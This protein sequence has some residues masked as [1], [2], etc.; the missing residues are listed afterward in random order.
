[1]GKKVLGTLLT[2]A[3]L[4]ACNNNMQS[5]E[6]KWAPTGKR[7]VG[8]LIEAT[9]TATIEKI[10]AQYPQA[11][12]R[13]LNPQHGLYEVFGITTEQARETAPT[14]SSVQRNSYFEFKLQ[15][16]PAPVGMKIEG[17]NPCKAASQFPTAIATLS[18]PSG[19][20][21]RVRTVELGQKIAVTSTKSKAHLLNPSQ[22]KTA[23]IVVA[24][25]A[26]KMGEQVKLMKDFEFTPD[27][28]G[29]YNIFVI[30]QDSRDVCAI[31]GLNILAT[32]NRSFRPSQQS[33]RVDL[34]KIPHLKKV[35][36]QE[37][38][39]I[40]QGAGITIAIIDTGVNY[41]HPLLAPNILVNSK[42]T[43]GAGRDGDGNGFKDDQIGY[44]FVNSDP[45]PYDDDGHGTHVAGLAAAKQ[46][47]MA[48]KAK[49]LPVKAMTSIGGDAGS[50]AAA[51]Q[52]A[53]D[54]GAKIINLS[55]GTVGA[56]AHPM[57]VKAV[58]Y[59]EEKGVLLV[60]ASGNGDAH[61][62]LGL[63]IDVTPV[64]PAA[65]PNENILSVGASSEGEA[66]APYS[67]FGAKGVDVVVP[68]GMAPADPMISTSFETPTNVKFAAM[69]GTSMASPVVAGIAAQVW[70]EEPR[71]T[72]KEVKQI[73]MDA[74][75]EVADLKSVT[76][77]GRHLNALAAL[78]RSRVSSV[79]F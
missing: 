16:V 76:V 69:S 25:S 72:Y 8:V 74:G 66:L 28:L 7:D 64:F 40:S 65:L 23:I 58:N 47:G 12:V 73:L 45:F 27:A 19:V 13:N 36:A 48:Q 9:D 50:I 46:I 77:S 63:D 24:P 26:S 53:T 59:A 32:A 39:A 14:A 31:D 61:T 49:L 78:Q 1:M 38:W 15:S 2:L 44:D 35:S 11:Q 4:T 75:P 70:A 67:N 62:G 30:V 33:G 55:L 54:R 41:N 60:V 37:S 10:L 68:G 17:L 79:L 22:L 43:E 29:V 3:A 57:I 5:R 51:I 42:E 18:E 21:S 52:Y 34:E 71:M 20:S 56:Q 6:R